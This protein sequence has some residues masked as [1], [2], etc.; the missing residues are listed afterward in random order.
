M[1]ENVNPMYYLMAFSIIIASSWVATKIKSSINPESDE[2]EIIKKYLLNESPL[3]GYN[4][5]KLWIHSKYEYNARHWESFHSRSSTD[6]NQ[7][8]I[9]ITVRSIINHCGDDFNICLID[10]NTFSKLIPSWDIDLKTVAEP[11][12][13]QI[14]EQG[15]L[16]LL[17]YYGGMVVPN[18]FLCLKNLKDLYLEGTSNKTSA[19][20]CE[21]INNTLNIASQKNKKAF[22]PSTYMVGT[23]KNNETI[24]NL[25]ELMKSKNRTPHFTNENEF[26][27]TVQ[28]WCLNET[29][30]GKLN[31]INGELI[32]IK[33]AKS[34]KP[35]LLEDLMGENFIDLSEKAYGIYIPEEELLKRVKYQ[36]FAVMDSNE[37][38]NKNIIISK[39]MK[40]SIIDN[41]SNN[42]SGEIKSA[43]SI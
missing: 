37:I 34:R 26:L 28:Q 7:P 39:Y 18:S 30:G 14:R 19:F 43:V 9:H 11:M 29:K 12:R 33:T 16:S 5:P 20:V 13:S 36:W 32:G 4:K 6:L 25:I 38:L 21:S 31:L 2:Y 24:H 8:Y 22:I 41:A 35:I 15:L 27:G 40:Q 10:D 17:Y 3:Y 1:F 42:S 23:N